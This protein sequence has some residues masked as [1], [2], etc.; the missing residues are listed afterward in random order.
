MEVLDRSLLRHA[1]NAHCKTGI[2]WL[3]ADM[4]KL[5]L[6]LLIKIRG[7]MYLWHILSRDKNELI[8]RIYIAQSNSSSV[9]NWVRL[10][11]DDKKELGIK[12][13]DEEIQGVSENK[14][15]LFVKIWLKGNNLNI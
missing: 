6:R 8:H 1:I 2:E 11:E 12:M 3:Y 14:F 15:K 5:N 13:S 7:L 9:G 4:G 10:V